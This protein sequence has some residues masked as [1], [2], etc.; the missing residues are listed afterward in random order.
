MKNIKIFLYLALGIFLFW[1]LSY[2]IIFFVI[3]DWDSRGTFGDTFGAI[4]SLFAGL[5]FAGIIYTILLQ[6]DELTLQRKDLNLQTK[7]LQLQVDEIARSANQL[8]MQRKLMN[9]QTVQTSINNL[10]SVHRNSIDDIDILFE[11]NT[12]NGKKA[13][14]PVHEAIAKKTL[15]ISDIDAH[16]NNCFNTFFYILQ[17]INGSDIDDN[18]KKVL[19]Q[20]LSIHTSDSELFLIYK[21]NENEKQQI[22][23]FE[24]YGFYERYTKILIKNYN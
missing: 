12:L 9:Y 16:M 17:F 15:D 10:I 5:A 22:L 19:A 11:N 23:L 7:V 4:N 2:V 18:Q 3:C 6:K 1:V 24:R 20:I 21:A 13:F 8:E 14:L